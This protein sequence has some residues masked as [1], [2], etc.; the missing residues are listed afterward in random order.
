MTPWLEECCSRVVKTW[1]EP[2]LWETALMS[3]EATPRP[4]VEA[5]R[6]ELLWRAGFTGEREMVEVALEVY[7]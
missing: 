5:A 2:D 3:G 7:S 6:G 1:P 4:L